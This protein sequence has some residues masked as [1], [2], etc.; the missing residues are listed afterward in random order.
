MVGMGFTR[1]EIRDSLVSQKYNEVTATYLLLGRKNEVSDVC[2]YISVIRWPVVL[3]KAVNIWNNTWIYL[4]CSFE[5]SICVCLYLR[6]TAVS[7]GRAA[8]WVSL[9]SGPAPSPTEPANTPPP[10]PP[11]VHPLRPLATRRSAAPRPTTARD[12]ILTSVMQITSW[13]LAWWV[14]FVKSW[15]LRSPFLSGGPA[16]PGSTHPK[17]SPS[18]VGEGAGLKEERLSIRKPSTNTVSSRSTPTPS[19]PMVSSAHNPNKAEIPDRRKEVNS[20]TVSILRVWWI[21]QCTDGTDPPSTPN[22]ISW[23]YSTLRLH[24]HRYYEDSKY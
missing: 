12:D 4:Y 21:I 14:R 16:V 11:L 20:T 7:L 10:L 19:S 9:E 6:L 18:G 1:D 13:D 3:R 24:W 5:S 15:R 17:R 22:P 23:D 8:V 2:F